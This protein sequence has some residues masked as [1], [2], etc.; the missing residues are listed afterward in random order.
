MGHIGNM[1]ASKYSQHV[2]AFKLKDGII[3]V[4]NAKTEKGLWYLYKPVAVLDSRLP[5]KDIGLAVFHSLSKAEIGLPEPPAQA[6]LEAVMNSLYQ[7]AGVQSFDELLQQHTRQC[8]VGRDETGIEITPTRNGG[9]HGNTKGFQFL[10]ELRIIIE[11]D[12]SPE[13]LGQALWQGFEACLL[14][15]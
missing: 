1:D 13:Q 10:I 9:A 4:T 5:V 11:P 15:V 2:S 12:A 6:E 14:V 7:A 8:S 3:L